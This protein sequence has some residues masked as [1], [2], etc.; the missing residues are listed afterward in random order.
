MSTAVTAMKVI[1]WLA[2]IRLCAV[3]YAVHYLH[4]DWEPELTRC[5]QQGLCLLCDLHWPHQTKHR[6]TTRFEP[7]S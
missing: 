1:C 2:F 4:I 7:T 5:H 3:I 6:H